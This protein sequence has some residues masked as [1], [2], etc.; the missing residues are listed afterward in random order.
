M[1]PEGRRLLA[2]FAALA[3]AFVLSLVVVWLYDGRTWRE[4]SV[5]NFFIVFASIAYAVFWVVDRHGPR[6]PPQRTGAQRNPTGDVPYI[7]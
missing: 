1:S 5:L 6:R 4:S 2:T 7:A 3:V